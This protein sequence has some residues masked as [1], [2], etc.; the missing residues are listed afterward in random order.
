VNARA[1]IGV[2]EVVDELGEILDGV[3]VVVGGGEIS[4]TPGVE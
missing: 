4:P 3:D 1:V 2:L